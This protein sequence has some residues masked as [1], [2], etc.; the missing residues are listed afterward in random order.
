MPSLVNRGVLLLYIYEKCFEMFIIPFQ[1]T[2]FFAVLSVIFDTSLHLMKARQ[3][4]RER[5][6]S[7]PTTNRQSDGCAESAEGGEVNATY[8]EEH[9]EPNDP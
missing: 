2:S 5:Q 3:M 1:T 8:E 9:N 6:F 7:A 4:Y